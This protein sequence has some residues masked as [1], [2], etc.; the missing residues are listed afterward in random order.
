[1]TER[2]TQQTLPLWK[3]EPC[4]EHKTRGTAAWRTCQVCGAM[5]FFEKGEDNEVVSKSGSRDHA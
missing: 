3:R 4:E 5:L 1:M 2:P